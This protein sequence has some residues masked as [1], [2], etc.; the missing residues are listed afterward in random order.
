MTESLLPNF[1]IVCNH[2]DPSGPLDAV[3]RYDWVDQRGVWE[4]R[5]DTVNVEYLE[6]DRRGWWHKD[7]ITGDG[8]YQPLGPSRV[9]HEI[10]GQQKRC[11]RRR[12]RIPEEHLQTVLHV[13]AVNKMFRTAFVAAAQADELV[14]TL[15][16]LR[17]ARDMA[18]KY[19]LLR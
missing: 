11:C 19:G 7:G 6:G 1:F 13:I 8:S 4:E 9:R 15:D 18:D 3:T 16:G 5:G 14:V 12:V 10:P 2:G 17:R